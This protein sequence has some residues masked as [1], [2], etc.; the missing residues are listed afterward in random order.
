[1][2][3]P[4]QSFHQPALLAEVL[5]ILALEPGLTV[6]DGTLGGGGHAAAIL[7]RSAPDGV[8][9]GLDLDPN[10]L[11]AASERL[12]RFGAR[13]KLVRASFRELR[14]VLSELGIE[15]VDAVLLDLGVSSHQIDEPE[16]GFRFA[17]DS[18]AETPLDMRLGRADD[19][20][21][22]AQL[23]HETPERELARI[24]AELG[25]L[26]GSYRLARRI[27]EARRRAPLRSAA[28]LLAVIEAAG[29]GRGRRHHAATLVFQALRIAVNDELGALREGIEAAIACLR[30]GGRLA[31]ISYHSL[32]DRIVKQR[33]REAAR[34]CSCPPGLP[35]CRCGGRVRLKLLTRRP[36]RPGE[37][38]VRANPRARSARLRAALRSAEAA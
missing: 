28:D 32:E 11:A 24:F 6:V 17:A 15:S 35:E 29:V 16:R 5:E 38:E 14:R 8:L 3:S 36:V 33:F 13:V 4:I 18:A 34:G 25:E 10:A 37:A 26:P 2:A 31:I 19:L 22:A 30:P 9:V 12:A 7:E 1:M 27:A 23:L 20:R 21:T